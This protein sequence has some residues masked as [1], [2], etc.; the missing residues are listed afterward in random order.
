M[1]PSGAVALDMKSVNQGMDDYQVDQDERILFSLKVRKIANIIFEL[2][3]KEAER[4][5][6]AATKKK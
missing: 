3:G 6:K 1:G 5:R 2:H 4:Q